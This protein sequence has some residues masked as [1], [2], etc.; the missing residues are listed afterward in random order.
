MYHTK[1]DMFST[2]S[3]KLNN[4]ICF[5]TMYSGK[6]YISPKL[7]RPS[8]IAVSIINKVNDDTRY[9]LINFLVSMLQSIV[10]NCGMAVKDA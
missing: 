2:F 3:M 8:I 6:L 5:K 9:D 4:F 10:I 1:Q 7:P